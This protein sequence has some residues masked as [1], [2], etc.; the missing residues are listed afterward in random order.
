VAFSTVAG[1]ARGV[2][3]DGD[4]RYIMLFEQR[5]DYFPDAAITDHDCVR[6]PSGRLDRQLGI[7]YQRIKLPHDCAII[8]NSRASIICVWKEW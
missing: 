8:L 1:D 7:D 4:V 3:I 5:A 6:L 2:M